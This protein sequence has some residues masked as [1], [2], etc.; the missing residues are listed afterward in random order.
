MLGKPELK[1]PNLARLH[2]D[3]VHEL[4]LTTGG[5]GKE[6][7]FNKLPSTRSIQE[8]SKQDATCPTQPPRILAGIRLG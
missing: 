7:E 8:R 3:H 6:H 1:P 4:Y 2:S 5:P